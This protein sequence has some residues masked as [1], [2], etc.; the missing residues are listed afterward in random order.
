MREFG[1][2]TQLSG[3][4][5]VAHPNLLDPNFRR[6]VLVLS[7]HDA[8]EGSLGFIINRPTGRMVG[9][10]LAGREDLGALARV[11]VCL[12][13]PVN[14]DRL[15][16]A[17]LRWDAGRHQVECQPHLAPEDALKLSH[18]A[19]IT[20]RAFVGY[21]GWSA[22]QLEA[23]VTQRA[24]VVKPGRPDVLELAGSERLW[25]EIMRQM[26]PWYRLMAAAPEDPSLN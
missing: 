18:D 24:W 6:S 25:P 10:L 14:Q 5:L 8:K 21:A 2:S 17:A 4:L 11:P 13:G 19:A 16:F 3:S 1:E 23:E 7:A 9:D 26:G 12:G 15:V 20:V 22:G